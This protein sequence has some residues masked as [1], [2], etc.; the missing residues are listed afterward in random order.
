MRLPRDRTSTLLIPPPARGSPVW[1]KG[2]PHQAACRS[3]F[4]GPFAGGP[5][6]AGRSRPG[7][8]TCADRAFE[9]SGRRHFVVCRGTTTLGGRREEPDGAVGTASAAE[10]TKA[11]GCLERLARTKTMRHPL[12][13]IVLKNRRA[14]RRLYFVCENSRVSLCGCDG[15]AR[16]TMNLKADLGIR[17]VLLLPGNQVVVTHISGDGRVTKRDLKGKQLWKDADT[18][19]PGRVPQLSAV[20]QRQSVPCNR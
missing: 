7:Q 8:L 12:T 2:P 4:A 18:A 1:R 11:L 5:G 15:K 9:R 6:I 13:G 19:Q 10:R 16:W 3:D 20:A 17:N 14:V